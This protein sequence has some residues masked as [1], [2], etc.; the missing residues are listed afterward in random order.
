MELR[1][2]DGKNYETYVI[3]S[4]GLK[5]GTISCADRST[6]A[7]SKWWGWNSNGSQSPSALSREG[8]VEWVEGQ[9][10]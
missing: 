6:R 7:S 4:E 8:A 2:L 5:L 9:Y 1:Q 3:E 10:K